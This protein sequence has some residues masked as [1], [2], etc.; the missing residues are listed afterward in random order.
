MNGETISISSII[1][2]LLLCSKSG[3]TRQLP[4]YRHTFVSTT[5]MGPRSRNHI[6]SLFPLLQTDTFIGN[7][8]TIEECFGQRPQN[9]QQYMYSKSHIRAM[10]S[11]TFP[12]QTFPWFGFD[13]EQQ[14]IVSDSPMIQ[15]LV[16]KSNKIFAE[17][18]SAARDTKTSGECQIPTPVVISEEITGVY[19]KINQK[20]LLP[21]WMKPSDSSQ[22]PML[23]SGWG[24]PVKP[25]A[26]TVEAFMCKS[27][28]EGFLNMQET[29]T[30]DLVGGSNFIPVDKQNIDGPESVSRKSL[31][32]ISK[33]VKDYISA[34]RSSFGSDVTVSSNI[35]LAAPQAGGESTNTINVNSG[36]SAMPVKKSG[37]VEIQ[38][39]KSS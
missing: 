15:E 17:L 13:S 28:L 34:Y 11:Q 33:A 1:A 25:S 31:P 4:I 24:T 32:I 29:I 2:I 22:P 6:F 12:D 23:A 21:P 19:S 7:A 3:D 38:K 27:N 16:T 14:K 10:I 36:Q 37:F 35:S 5:P 26:A 9:S 20:G 18:R 30:R 39:F 8:V